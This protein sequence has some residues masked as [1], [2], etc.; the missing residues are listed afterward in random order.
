[1]FFGYV[2]AA[3]QSYS[4]LR[5]NLTSTLDKISLENIEGKSFMLSLLLDFSM[6]ILVR[7]SENT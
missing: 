7:E 3:S 2:N 5:K 6:V 1:M 4:V